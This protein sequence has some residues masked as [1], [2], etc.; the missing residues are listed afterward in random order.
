VPGSNLAFLRLPDGVAPVDLAARL[1]FPTIPVP[2]GYGAL[3]DWQVAGSLLYCLHSG[4]TANPFGGPSQQ[5]AITVVDLAT[6]TAPFTIPLSMAPTVQLLRAGPGSAG[7]ALFVYG[8]ASGSLDE[9][10]QGTLAPVGSIPVGAGIAAME[11]TTLG[12]EW[13]LLCAGG[14]CSAPSLM[15]LPVGTTTVLNRGSLPSGVQPVIAVSPSASYGKA[16]FA[17]GPSTAAP[18]RTDPIVASPGSAA[19]PIASS[20][21]LVVSN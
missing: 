3:V 21:F 18:F 8:H 14:S 10:A 16:S 12:S 9:F 4:Q 17:I 13:L 5:P 2:G 11:L 15:T 19:L 20:R 1:V 6:L 7:P